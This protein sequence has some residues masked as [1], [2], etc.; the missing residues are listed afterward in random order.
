MTLQILPSAR[1]RRSMGCLA[2]AAPVIL[3][4]S[5]RG[6]RSARETFAAIGGL[7]WAASVYRRIFDRAAADIVGDPFD[8]PVLW[9]DASA[10]AWEQAWR[11]AEQAGNWRVAVGA[12]ALTVM[13]ALCAAAV[14]ILI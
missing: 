14:Q 1:P 10:K 6:A 2:A 4:V 7:I 12:G 5:R 13:L 3:A 8:S 9:A 11:S